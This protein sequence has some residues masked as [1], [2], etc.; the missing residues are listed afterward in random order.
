MTRFSLVVPTIHRTVELERQL[1]SLQNQNEDAEILIVDQN[2]DDRLTPIIERFTGKLNLSRLRSSLSGAAHARNVG[3]DAA[4]GE[5][6]AFPDDDAWYPSG[7]LTKISGLFGSFP[8]FDGIC[9][10]STDAD[11]RD[12]GIRWRKQPTVINRL[13]LGRTSI[14]FSMF[15]RRNAVATLR[16]NEE[17][18]PGAGTPWG[19]GEGADFLLHLF[20]RGYKI[21]YEPHLIVHHPSH[22]S[23]PASDEKILAYARGF[24]RVLRINGYPPALAAV[25]CLKPLGRAAMQ[26]ARLDLKGAALSRKIAFSRYAGYLAK[27]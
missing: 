20:N 17:L 9:V 15:L 10:R 23:H 14:E 4:S 11:G 25:F 8:E 7:L 3:L 2:L 21:R 1:T 19:A 18:G 5:I 16:F 6:V 12:A 26:T 27:L 22:Q 24:G 13:N